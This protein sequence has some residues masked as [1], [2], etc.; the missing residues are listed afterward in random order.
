MEDR[1]TNRWLVVAGGIL[2]Q[3]CLGAIY[4][5]SAFTGKLTDPQGPFRFSRSETQAVFSVGLITFTTVMALFAGRWQARVGPRLVAMAGGLLLGA[6]YVLAS[7]WSDF[8]GVLL[9]IGL[10]GGAGIG[11]AYVCPIAALVKWFPDRKG[12]ISGLAVAGFGFGALVW[13]KLTTGFRFGPVD[14]TPGWHG[15]FGAPPAGP[16]WSV[17]Q[18]F[19][20]YGALFASIVGLGALALADPPP[21]WTPRG[22]VPPPPTLAASTGGVEYRAL[23]MARTSQFWRVFAAF[24]FSATAGLMVIGVIGLFGTEA[25][26]RSG[27][28]GPRAAVMTATAMGLFFALSNALGRVTWGWISERTGRRAGIVVMC[29]LQGTTM[30]LFPRLADSEAGL[31]AAAAA[32]GFNFGGNYALFPA[33]T[34][35]FFGNRSLGTNYPWVFMAGGVAGVAGP[36]LGGYMG[37]RQAWGWA[38]VLSGLACFLGAALV[39]TLRPP[40]RTGS[41]A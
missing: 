23:E 33:I 20:L 21:G 22:W 16:G 34:A 8:R 40:R 30:I 39:V 4:A 7:R 19:L 24:F 2:V 11:L 41:P 25:L 36:L 6:G 14:L 18:V 10:L 3:L 12:F 5:W 28:S 37:D 9:G 32:V 29:L 31:Y 1:V 35:D 38:F 27:T 13:V 17:E 15:L 26:V